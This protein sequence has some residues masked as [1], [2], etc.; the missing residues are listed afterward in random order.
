MN[1]KI[2]IVVVLVAILIFAGIAIGT[3]KKS[4]QKKSPVNQT[5]TVQKQRPKS[6]NEAMRYVSEAR[7]KARRGD[8]VGAMAE[9][10]KALKVAPEVPIARNCK[11]IVERYMKRK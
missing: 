5:Q 3:G 6:R 10:D 9:C 4:A 2:G 11:Q 7:M 1:K 8:Y